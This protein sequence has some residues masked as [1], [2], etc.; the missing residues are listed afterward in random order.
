M[1]YEDEQ[2]ASRRDVLRGGALGVGALVGAMGVTGAAEA[3]TPAV[4]MAAASTPAQ[5][6]FLQVDGVD[7]PATAKG[8]E[9]QIP[10]QAY[11]WGVTSTGSTTTGGGGGAGKTTPGPFVVTIASSIASPPLLLACCT[12]KHFAKATLRGV[13]TGAKGK[14]TQYLTITLTE[15]LISSLQQSEGS[16]GAPLDIVSLAFARVTYTESGHTVTFDF[17]THHV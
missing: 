4:R 8:F 1:S 17:N 14:P 13:R 11:S 15:V 3:S 5:R 7:G 9:K 10:V 2:G 16:G 12:G 6:F